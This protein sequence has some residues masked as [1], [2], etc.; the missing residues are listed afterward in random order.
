MDAFELTGSLISSIYCRIISCQNINVLRVGYSKVIIISQNS[1]EKNKK[2][3]CVRTLYKD[4]KQKVI[5]VFVCDKK[6]RISQR[7]PLIPS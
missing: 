4:G 5:F 2:V 3:K 7:S 6:K 1:N